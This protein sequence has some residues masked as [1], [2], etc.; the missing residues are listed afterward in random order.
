MLTEQEKQSRYV[1]QKGQK[2]RYAPDQV[3]KVDLEQAGYTCIQEPGGAKVIEA[4]STLKVKG[5]N[6][7][8]KLSEE[9]KDTTSN[10]DVVNTEELQ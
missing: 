5:L 3:M 9:K 7:K 1:M 2:I 4:K 8:S 6:T 10:D